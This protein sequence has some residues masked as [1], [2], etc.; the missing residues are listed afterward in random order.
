MPYKNNV[1]N[2][3]AVERRRHWRDRRAGSDRRNPARLTLS[4]Y[5]CRSAVPRRAADISGELTDGDI[6]WN[7]VAAKKAA[8]KNE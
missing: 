5:D 7:G 8:T 4:N 6:W 2:V 1:S 3:E